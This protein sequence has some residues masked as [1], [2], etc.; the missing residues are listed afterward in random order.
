MNEKKDANHL[1]RDHEKTSKCPKCG[2]PVTDPT[3]SECLRCGII[4]EKYYLVKRR[5]KLER[6]QR[7]DDS[8]LKAKDVYLQDIAISF[9]LFNE[10]INDFPNTPAA[11]KAKEFLEENSEKYEPVL[12]SKDAGDALCFLGIPALTIFALYFVI[13]KII[14]SEI[15]HPWSFFFITL[16]I[17]AGASVLVVVIRQKGTMPF[18]Q[19]VFVFI[20][21]FCSIGLAANI[22]SNGSFSSGSA[23]VSN[24][25]WDSS[26]SQVE[27]YLEKHLKDPDSYQGDGW[28]DV[29]RRGD[30]GFQVRHKYRAK[31]S[32]GGYVNKNKVFILDSKGN[33]KKTYDY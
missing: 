24:S 29:I 16:L 5:K 23:N 3:F 20:A 13:D 33:V 27:K 26:V 11:A 2:S 4:F 12:K 22:C 17:C 8:F 18:R 28:S 9:K 15:A 19:M 31:N 7:A 32:F 10:T 1:E 14:S 30:G 21:W 6:L 25:P